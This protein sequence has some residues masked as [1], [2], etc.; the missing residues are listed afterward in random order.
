MEHLYL[1]PLNCLCVAHKSAQDKLFDSL[2]EITLEEMTRLHSTKYKLKVDEN[3]KVQFFK[4][5]YTGAQIFAIIFL[6]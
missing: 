2:D 3:L 5:I 1:K 4:I 6:I